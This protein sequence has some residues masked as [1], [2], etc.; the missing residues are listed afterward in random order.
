MAGIT[1][2]E[3]MQNV[4]GVSFIDILKGK[5]KEN[6]RSLFWHYPNFW[7]PSGPGIGPTSAIRKGDWK[8]IYYHTDQSYELFNI[9]SD[10]GE[11]TN[12]SDSEIEKR[13]ELA[14]ELGKYLLDSHAQM[15]YD[16]AKTSY[17]PLPG[18]VLE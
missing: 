12:L 4:D 3:T 17:V 13:N 5:N 9:G 14:S 1:D 8:L 7:G 16:S 10:L 11:S 2:Y 6:S 15:P 18:P